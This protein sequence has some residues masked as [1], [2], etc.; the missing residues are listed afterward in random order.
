MTAVFF[1]SFW[2]CSITV[3]FIQISMDGGTPEQFFSCLCRF[4]EAMH[5]L[6][7]VAGRYTDDLFEMF[8]EMR[9]HLYLH[10][11]TLLLKLAQD[12]QQTWRS[13]TDMAALCYLLAYQVLPQHVSNAGYKA[14]QIL[15]SVENIHTD[16]FEC[17]VFFHQVQRPK[18]KMTKRD[19]SCLQLLEQ[20][21]NDRQ[22]QAGHMLFNLS[23]DATTLIR[24][25]CLCLLVLF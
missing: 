7:S 15:W 9:G 19:Q 16:Y 17:S 25:V 23:T 3:I 10:A 20:L 13:V 2:F 18:S 12:R 8:V 14:N 22:S 21:A 1:A 4:D 6:S 5:A 11:G 24:E